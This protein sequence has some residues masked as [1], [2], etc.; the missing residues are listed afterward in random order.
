MANKIGR[1]KKVC[2]QYKKSGHREINKQIKQDRNQKRI[3]RFAKRKSSGI[4]YADTHTKEKTEAKISEYCEK[5]GISSKYFNEN[6]DSIL[7][8]IFEPNQGSNQAKHTEISRHRS[9]M[10]KLDNE[11]S[12]K[13]M[14]EKKRSENKRK[15]RDKN[16]SEESI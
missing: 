11:V 4:S 10:R 2:E 15:S 5:N 16:N 3:A 8:H 6:K 9:I 14:E 7:K 1:N 12:A 13:K